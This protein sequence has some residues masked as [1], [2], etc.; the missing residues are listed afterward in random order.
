MKLF[1]YTLFVTSLALSNII[2][3]EGLGLPSPEVLE[4]KLREQGHII[5]ATEPYDP[6][7]DAEPDHG[8]ISRSECKKISSISTKLQDILTDATGNEDWFTEGEVIHK[9]LTAWEAEKLRSEFLKLIPLVIS[10]HKKSAL[11]DQEEASVSSRYKNLMLELAQMIHLQVYNLVREKNATVNEEEWTYISSISL[12]GTLF[13]DASWEDRSDYLPTAGAFILDPVKATAELKT[14]SLEKLQAFLAG[15]DDIG[16]FKRYEDAGDG[17]PALKT[18]YA[19]NK[20]EIQAKFAEVL[21]HV[22]LLE[23]QQK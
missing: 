7:D 3:A 23:G 20:V 6:K 21:A 9:K 5:D 18:K 19:A 17:M 16:F 22:V 4:H 1:N 11:S 10:S 8:K 2:L 13:D 15:D 14:K 12:Y